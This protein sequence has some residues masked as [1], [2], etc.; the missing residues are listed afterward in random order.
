MV[1]E[2]LYSLVLQLS[3]T[4]SVLFLTTGRWRE[5]TESSRCKTHKYFFAIVSI[6]M[7]HS[8]IR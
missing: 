7:R 5:L 8:I 4:Y 1:I 6:D 3:P 2:Y